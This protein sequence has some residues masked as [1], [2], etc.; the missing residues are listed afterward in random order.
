[1]QCVAQCG[2]PA[3]AGEFCLVCA[4]SW[5]R[6]VK[7]VA[8]VPVMPRFIRVKARFAGPPDFLSVPR[9]L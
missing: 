5:R 6:T 8:P 7:P 9:P 2:S 3:V 1:M 4:P